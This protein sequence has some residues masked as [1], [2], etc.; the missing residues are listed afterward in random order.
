MNIL[1]GGTCGWSMWIGPQDCSPLVN[2]IE[3]DLTT[4]GGWDFECM[5]LEA[6]SSLPNLQSLHVF[7]PQ[8]YME[9][10]HSFPHLS[11]LTKLC[12]YARTGFHP[13]VWN[14][15]CVA[16]Q[17]LQHLEIGGAFQAK[18]TVLGLLS[19]F[20]IWIWVPQSLWMK[21]AT[22]CWKLLQNG[23]QKRGQMFY[24]RWPCAPCA[25]HVH[26]EGC[27]MLSQV[28]LCWCDLSFNKSGAPTPVCSCV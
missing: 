19:T 9:Y 16:L 2:L 17:A 28:C 21:Q 23:L 10:D 4:D 6:I 7:S 15:N 27:W 22:L 1:L 12:I 25:Q 18:P 5:D 26:A 8:P 11:G 13:F 20:T 3:V 14:L 24:F